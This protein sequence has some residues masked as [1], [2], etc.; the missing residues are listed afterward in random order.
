MEWKFRKGDYTVIVTT[1]MVGGLKVQV[2]DTIKT[3][4]DLVKNKSMC[5][6][7][8]TKPLKLERNGST[9]LV[10]GFTVTEQMYN[11]MLEETT[12]IKSECDK[13]REEQKKRQELE[14]KQLYADYKSGK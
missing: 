12:R 6:L 4:A 14:E 10:P 9:Y 13:E 2:T 3:Y 8:F 11:E 7:E 5:G 1:T